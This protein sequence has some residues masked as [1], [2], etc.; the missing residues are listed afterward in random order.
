MSTPVTEETAIY[1]PTGD[2]MVDVIDAALDDFASLWH[3]VSGHPETVR[4]A[5]ADTYTDHLRRLLA[6]RRPAQDQQSL[7]FPDPVA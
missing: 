5:V 1:A 3:E 2:P 4:L 7:H 6:Q